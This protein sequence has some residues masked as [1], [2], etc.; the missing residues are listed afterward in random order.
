M[1]DLGPMRGLL[2]GLGISLLLW[3]IIVVL[4]VLI[5]RFA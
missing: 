2:Y 3:A 1:N 5:E 4:G